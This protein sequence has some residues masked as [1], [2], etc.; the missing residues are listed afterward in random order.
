MIEIKHV[1]KNYGSKTA[2]SDVTLQLPQGTV[3]TRQRRA[4]QLLKLDLE[5]DAQ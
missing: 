2:L 3:A 5:E 1:R 4:L